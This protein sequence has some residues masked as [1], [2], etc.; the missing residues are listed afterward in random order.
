MLYTLTDTETD[1]T[2]TLTLPA[3]DSAPLRDFLTYEDPAP[4]IRDAVA[5]TIDYLTHYPDGDPDHLAFLGLRLTAHDEERP[6]WW[7]DPARPFPA[8]SKDEA[9]RLARLTYEDALA[10]TGSPD[11]DAR[12]TR[13]SFIQRT[14]GGRIARGVATH[15][16]AAAEA[17][18]DG[19]AWRA[20]SKTIAVGF[21]EAWQLARTRWEAEHHALATGARM[22]GRVLQAA[23]T[24]MGLEQAELATRLNVS[25]GSIRDWESERTLTPNGVTSEIYQMLRDWLDTLPDTDDAPLPAS[26]PLST[27]RAQLIRGDGAPV[28]LDPGL[29][30]AHTWDA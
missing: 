5:A 20:S 19:R 21:R 30:T 24:T 25:L 28:A 8:L 3:D 18:P 15:A 22:S 27:I 13:L 9:R 2:L 29:F 1:E 23:R 11:I 26:A 4:Q 17:A 12:L 10:E 14:R 6:E 7:I 16:N